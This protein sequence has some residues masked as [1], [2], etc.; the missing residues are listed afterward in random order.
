MGAY[1]GAEVCELVGLYLL[2]KIGHIL[3]PSN[4]GLYRDDGLAAIP[5]TNGSKLDRLRK[6]LHECFKAE[7][8]KIEVQINAVE[9]DFLD[10][11][12]CM[13]SGTFR[14]FMKPNNTV[15]Y[16]HANSNHPRSITKNIPTMIEKRL[17][18]LSSSKQIFEDE[19]TPYEEALKLSGYETT[20]SYRSENKGPNKQR[21]RR[22]ILWF[23]PPYSESVSTNVG[24][25]FLNILKR[26]FPPNHKYHKICNRN[27][28]KVSYSCMSNMGNIIKGHNM[29]ILSPA[30]KLEENTKA[31]NCRKK[32]QCP[33]N[34]QCLVKGII[35]QGTISDGDN[36]EKFT[37][38]GQ[39][40]GGFKSRYNNHNM[41]FRNEKYSTRT[42]LSKKHWEIK[43]K[44]GS[45]KTTW[46]I[47][48][49]VK[50]YENG[51]KHCNLCLTEKLLI[52]KC[53]HKNLLN[54]RSEISAKCRHKKKFLL[55]T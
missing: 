2:Q 9:V 48:K 54:S 44:G 37:Y 49:L 4:V 46:E 29:S 33:L 50:T 35:Y 22:K 6:K 26:N 42:E 15:Q 25:E 36:G 3:P 24:R 23:N 5:N 7:N 18:N 34:G 38:I 47:L 12:L 14:P 16:V 55:I 10:V 52:M 28:V 53:R 39:A 51:Q 17:S 45:P 32:E 41:S 20:L 27:T 8:L 43:R 21:R 40:E 11:H 31:C 1:D 13:K 19:K 30:Q